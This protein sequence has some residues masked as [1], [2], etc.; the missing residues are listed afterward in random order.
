MTQGGKMKN[1]LSSRALFTALIIAIMV[2]AP[3]CATYKIERTGNPVDRGKVDLIKPTETTRAEI[4]A[5]FGEPTKSST[6]E[7]VETLTYRYEEIK[8]PHYLGDFIESKKDTLV[9]RTS[10]VVTI[11]KGLVHTFNY[12]SSKNK[13]LE[14]K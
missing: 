10:L 4:I 5:A 1:S 13:P 2:A 12:K 9:S 7:G 11:K 6:V 14:K 3:G 8:T